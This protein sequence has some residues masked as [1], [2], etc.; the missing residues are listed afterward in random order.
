MIQNKCDN[1]TW[2]STNFVE[3]VNI[4]TLI[5]LDKDIQY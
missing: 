5:L 1:K 2:V 4:L 3:T